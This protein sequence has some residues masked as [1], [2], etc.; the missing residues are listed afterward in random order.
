MMT[1]KE[2]EQSRKLR[3]EIGIILARYTPKAGMT[4]DEHRSME[5]DWADEI[6]PLDI[7]LEAIESRALLRSAHKWAIDLELE[8]D[9]EGDVYGKQFLTRESKRAL[10]RAISDARREFWK[11]WIGVL[12]PTLSLLVALASLGV[13]LAGVLLALYLAGLLS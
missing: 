11:Y 3:K 4:E 1:R 13:A 10:Q 2:R 12:A 8:Y 9:V 7:W 5:Q 6:R